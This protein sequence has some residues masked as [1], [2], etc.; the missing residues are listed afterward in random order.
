MTSRLHFGSG[1]T[2]VALDGGEVVAASCELPAEAG[3]H[4]FTLV[5]LGP[6][7]L[8]AGDACSAPH[9]SM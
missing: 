4:R 7:A 5:A 9:S 6:P 3:Q 8:P 1:G 2:G